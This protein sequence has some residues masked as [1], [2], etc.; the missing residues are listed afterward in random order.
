MIMKKLSVIFRAAA[1]AAL[2]TVP[3]FFPS[4]SD[5]DDFDPSRIEEGFGSSYEV[6]L[7]ADFSDRFPEGEAVVNFVYQAGNVPVSV[8]ADHYVR[9]GRSVLK[10]QQH[11]RQGEYVVTSVQTSGPDKVQDHHMGCSVNVGASSNTVSPENYD[12]EK[13]LLG[14]GPP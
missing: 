6:T 2:V 5:K 8:K 9:N 10:L 14:K 1:V 12:M 4:C 11:L 13:L 7:P 3:F